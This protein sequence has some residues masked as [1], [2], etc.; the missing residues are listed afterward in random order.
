MFYTIQV[1]FNTGIII[2]GKS[3]GMGYGLGKVP[4]FADEDVFIGNKVE[5][6]V[7]HDIEPYVLGQVIYS[8]PL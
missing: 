8:K 2:F 7:V 1:Q 3:N 4:F 6:G 5:E